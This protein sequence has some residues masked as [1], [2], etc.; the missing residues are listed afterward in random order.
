MAHCYFVLGLLSAI[1][2]T[3]LLKGPQ[4]LAAGVG[5]VIVIKIYTRHTD[6]NIPMVAV[7]WTAGNAAPVRVISFG[8]KHI[9]TRT[10]NL[11]NALG[12]VFYV[13]SLLPQCSVNSY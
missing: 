12:G 11:L 9:E 3:G 5:V 4:W 2:A 13:L 1:L 7:Q 8:S 6:G 10:V